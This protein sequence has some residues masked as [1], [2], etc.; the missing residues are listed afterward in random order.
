[1][2]FFNKI[3]GQNNKIETQQD[4]TAFKT[5]QELIERY[6]GIV[7]DKQLDFGDLIGNNNWNINIANGEIS[8]GTN[9]VFPI[10]VLGTIS[11]SSQTWLWAWANT[12][13]GLTDKVIQQALEL[14]KYGEDN[15][16]NIL[17]NDTF[18]FS[19]EDLH[20]IGTI[21]SGIHNSSAYYICDYGQGAMVVTIKSDQID[22]NRKD[23]HFRIMTVFP[24]LISQFDMN[25][26][27]ALTNYLTDKGYNISEN[28][29][30]LTATKNGDIVTAEFDDQSRL[31]KLNG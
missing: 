26:N 1:M 15:E 22:K 24:Q 31:I 14:K 19:K 3:F 29:V 18:D 21:A 11:H 28:G 2:G 6:G 17:K 10:Q 16:I 13:S 25:H 27:L 9:L 5:D 7:F 8:F 20:L 12:K 4:L 30:K 23:N